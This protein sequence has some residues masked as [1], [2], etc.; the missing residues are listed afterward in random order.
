MSGKKASRF[1]CRRIFINGLFKFLAQQDLD[2]LM[3]SSANSLLLLKFHFI[4]EAG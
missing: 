3:K 1:N 2:A 4:H